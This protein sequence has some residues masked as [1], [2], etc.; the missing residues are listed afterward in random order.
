MDFFSAAHI[1]ASGLYAQRVRMNTTSSNL[2][3]ADTTRTESGGPYQRMDPVFKAVNIPAFNQVLSAMESQ[4]KAVEVSEIKK[5]KNEPRIVYNPSHPDADEK[6]YVK[7]P[8]VNMV[9]E[10]VN[11]M[12]ATRTY[13]ASV[14][15]F[16]LL[17]QMAERAISIGKQS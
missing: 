15:A 14:K 4:V 2:A 7:M 6:G 3:N 9:E 1:L 16:G 8:N 12:T 17:T 13:E 10:M 5:D 11:M